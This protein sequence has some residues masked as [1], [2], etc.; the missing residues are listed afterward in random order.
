MRSALLATVLTACF[1]LGCGS[2]NTDKLIVGSWQNVQTPNHPPVI[3]R[4]D[5]TYSVTIPHPVAAGASLLL[6]GEYELSDGVLT[7]TGK[8]LKVVSGGP[9]ADS[10]RGSIAR[11]LL[12]T[13][14]TSI[15][16]VT[17]D[18]LVGEAQGK[19]VTFRRVGKVGS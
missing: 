10:F 4:A 15:T 7:T 18:E 11:D 12:K 3:Y 5:G 13:Q 16:W 9:V 19:K 2:P 17:K 8:D 6:T 1:L 14:K